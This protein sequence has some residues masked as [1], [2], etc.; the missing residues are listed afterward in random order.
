MRLFYS[1]LDKNKL[2][3]EYIAYTIHP[4]YTMDPSIT[5]LIKN[6][7]DLLKTVSKFYLNGQ[8]PHSLTEFIESHIQEE[9]S[10]DIIQRYPEYFNLL[11]TDD[12]QRE[13]EKDL[14]IIIPNAKKSLKVVIYV[15]FEI[16]NAYGT[17]ESK[18]KVGDSF[19][20]S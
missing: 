15:D 14:G 6:D 16:Y 2:E 10:P 7:D 17:T 19:I 12:V 18:I 11:S 3:N 20:S 8:L 5:I 4:N 9:I 13:H 1:T